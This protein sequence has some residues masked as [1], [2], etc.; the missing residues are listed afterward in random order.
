MTN[1]STDSRINN[2]LI[3][4]SRSFLQYVS[5][6]WLWVDDAAKGLGEQ[7]EV[8]AVRQRQD[9]GDLARLLNDR[10]WNIDFGAYPTEYT[11][12]QF[13]SLSALFNQ[14]IFAQSVIGDQL[15]TTVADLRG[16][17][18]LEAADWVEVIRLRESD[19]AGAL[20]EIQRD[21]QKAVAAAS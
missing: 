19:L 21:M 14:L 7:V 11:D 3:T 4:L 17:G 2:A 15:S 6:S 5:E 18:D 8:L 9:V 1:S 13:L 20:K 16:L 12:M 10:E